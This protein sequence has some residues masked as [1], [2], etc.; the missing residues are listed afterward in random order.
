MLLDTQKKNIDFDILKNAI[1]STAEHR[2][3]LNI[4]KEWNK[5]IEQLEISDIMKKQ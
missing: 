5:S 2:N 1:Y 3:T 4:I